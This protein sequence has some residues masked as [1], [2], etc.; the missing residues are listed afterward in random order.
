MKNTWGVIMMMGILM[1][2]CTAPNS[3]ATP[4]PPT[5]TPAPIIPT[6]TATATATATAVPPTATATPLP[7]PTIVPTPVSTA[8]LAQQLMENLYPEGVPAPDDMSASV[9]A[10]N[11]ISLK[12]PL[13][14]EPLW[15]AFSSGR[16]GFMPDEPKHFVAIFS[17]HKTGWHQKAS[18]ELTDPDYLDARSVEQVM[19][20]P[21]HIWLQLDGGAGAH[22]GIFSL[23]MFDGQTL[24]QKLSSFSASPGAGQVLDLD[25]DGLL[26]VL[27]NATD[28]Y[29]FCYACNV[30][31]PVYQVYRWNGGE[32]VAVTLTELGNDTPANLRE[33]NNRM[34][35]LAQAWLWKDALAAMDDA[36]ALGADNPTVAWN[37]RLITLHIDALTEEIGV[38]SYPLLATIF[39]GDY[40]GALKILRQYSAEELFSS[41]SPL[42]KDTPADGWESSLRDWVFQ[43][44]DLALAEKPDIATAHFLRGWAAFINDGATDEVRAEV[45][46]AVSLAPD[47]PLFA[48]GNSLLAGK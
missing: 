35:E 7:T 15:A 9:T 11:V 34:V 10:V 36:L 47:E 22:S 26:E 16:N 18:L 28:Y 40:E 2:A 37:S 30:R 31:L 25:G 43:A 39:Y 45:T 6:K 3:G 23:I 46:Q 33:A 42:V 41:D 4:V 1:V 21:T 20:E 12:V 8:D 14:S 38:S 44:T 24:S 27:L 5:H 48:K 13:G 19:L 32:L 29:V 17:H